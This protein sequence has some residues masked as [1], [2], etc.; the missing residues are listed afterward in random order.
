MSHEFTLVL[1]PGEVTDDQVNVLYENGLDDGT[2]ST[3][4]GITRIDVT[5]DAD[6]L[7]SAIRSA[8]G[9]VKAVGLTVAT[10]EIEADQIVHQAAT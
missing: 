2:V 1:M 5:C 8:I 10:V 7:E 6:S 4:R 9:Q 3:S